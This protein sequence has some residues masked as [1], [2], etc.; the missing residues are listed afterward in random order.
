ML[1]FTEGGRT[2]ETP[3]FESVDLRTA[4]VSHGDVGLNA[5][6]EPLKAQQLT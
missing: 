3:V 5:V 1:Y 6:L 4:P 2:V